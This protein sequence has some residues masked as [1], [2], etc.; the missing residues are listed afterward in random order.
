L[1]DP[2]LLFSAVARA[3]QVK[4]VPGRQL[5]ELLATA[6]AGGRALILLDNV[7][8][9]L[10]DA[11]RE[12]AALLTVTDTTLLVTSRE[13]LQLQGEQV[14]PVPTLTEEDGITLFLARARALDPRFE[15][16]ESIGE[17][18]FRLDFSPS[19]SSWGLR[20]RLSF[21]PTSCSS[22]SRSA[23]TC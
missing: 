7:E 8:H 15:A 19:P 20:E 1:R 23:S 16:S 13:R 22:A 9:L 18:C 21:P 2:V 14:Y 5:K 6:L 4:E 3:L 10:P 17:V 12:I 11:A